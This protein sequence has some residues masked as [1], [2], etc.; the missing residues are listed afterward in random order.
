MVF[1][2]ECYLAIRKKRK[3]RPIHPS[4]R[5]ALGY[6]DSESDEEVYADWKERTSRVCK[7]CWELKYCPYGPL[8]EKSPTIPALKEGMQEQI[9]YFQE[10]IKTKLVGG[11]TTLTPELRAQLE[12]WSQD[13]QIVLRQAFTELTNRR[14]LEAASELKTDGNC[15]RPALSRSSDAREGA[16]LEGQADGVDGVDGSSSRGF[17]DRSNVGIELRAPL[18][19]KAVG[20]LSIDRAGA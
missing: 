11:I 19:S 5:D 20:Y 17:D 16:A 18:A 7:P 12:E 4:I 14:R 6:K 3:Y 13:E 2:S 1:Q 15:S 10:C 8:V 9:E